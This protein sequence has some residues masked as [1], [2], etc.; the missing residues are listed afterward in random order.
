MQDFSLPTLSERRTACPSSDLR[1]SGYSSPRLTGTLIRIR[2]EGYGF[3]HSATMDYYVN[4]S[5]MR[6]RSAWREGQKVNF[7]P[8]PSKPGKAPP[9]YDV[10]AIPTRSKR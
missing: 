1:R 3:I 2:D 9:A 5:S 10:Q 6:D 7:L 8:G 4:V